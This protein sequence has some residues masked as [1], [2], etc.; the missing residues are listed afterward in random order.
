MPFV[1]YDEG[2]REIERDRERERRGGRDDARRNL[3]SATRMEPPA[4]INQPIRKPA[5]M[6]N[7][8]RAQKFLNATRSFFLRI[9]AGHEAR[10]ALIT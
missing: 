8:L 1:A 3:V 9:R 5:A 10:R 7:E 4:L 2:E 6:R